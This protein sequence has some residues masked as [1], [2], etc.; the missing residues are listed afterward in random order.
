[1]RPLEV[2]TRQVR[3]GDGTDITYQVT[4]GQG[5]WI[6]LVNGL[7]ASFKVWH[8]LIDY[9]GGEYRFLSWNYRELHDPAAPSPRVQRGGLVGTH[10]RDLETVLRAEEIEHAAWVSWSVGSQVVLEALGD[11]A[12]RATH[13]ILVN[14]TFGAMQAGPLAPVRSTLAPRILKLVEHSHRVAEAI[15]RRAAR[16]PETVSWVKRLG[17]VGPTID[18]EAL[19]EV[20]ASIGSLNMQAFFRNL[21]AFESHDAG[22]LLDRV[23]VPSLMITGQR[24]LLA[25]REKA[26]N[27]A[28]R[29]AGCESFL[30][31][32]STHYAPM[33]FPEL[34]NLRIEKFLREHGA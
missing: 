14:P 18:E 21:H 12:P 32:G 8:H 16:L 9:L 2:E 24:D 26:E 19:A 27:A 1:M 5:P 3:S 4:P 11:S 22:P 10:A 17:L 25:P 33:E 15:A 30:I 20:V 28:R 6:I 29:I 23:K 34:I 13:V 31:R 7:V